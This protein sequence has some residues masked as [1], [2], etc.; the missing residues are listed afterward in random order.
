[1]ATNK[2]LEDKKIDD[3]FDEEFYAD[4]LLDLLADHVRLREVALRT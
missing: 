3:V 1:M 4:E 2:S